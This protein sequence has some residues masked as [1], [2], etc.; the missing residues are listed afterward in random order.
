MMAV[1][2]NALA[3]DRYRRMR[4]DYLVNS[5]WSSIRIFF[6]TVHQIVQTRNLFAIDAMCFRSGD[7]SSAM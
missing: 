3:I 4:L 2:R 5:M 6:R 1:Q 7:H